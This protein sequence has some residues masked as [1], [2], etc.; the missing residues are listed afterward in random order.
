MRREAGPRTNGWAVPAGDERIAEVTAEDVEWADVT[1]VLADSARK[2]A[3]GEDVAY[4]RASG[5]RLV[6]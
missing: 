4:A 3:F 2:N 1:I 6:S 5:T